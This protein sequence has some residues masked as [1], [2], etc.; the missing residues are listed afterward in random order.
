MSPSESSIAHLSTMIANRSPRDIRFRGGQ[1]GSVKHGRT[2]VRMHRLFTPIR[3]HPPMRIVSSSRP[4]P[5][6]EQALCNGIDVNGLTQSDRQAQ[7]QMS[8]WSDSADLAGCMGR[9]ETERTV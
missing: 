1:R 4:V 5:T 2:L 9:I 6:S 8:V 7:L 3:S